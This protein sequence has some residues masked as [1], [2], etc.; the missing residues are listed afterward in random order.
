[1]DLKD[2]KDKWLEFLSTQEYNRYTIGGDVFDG[3]VVVAI[4]SSN[5]RCW[6]P[7]TES[8][9]YY[10]HLKSDEEINTQ[11]LTELSIH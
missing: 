4:F 7:G 6:K 11:I 5:G 9:E 10:K 3:D 2:A 8:N 1:M